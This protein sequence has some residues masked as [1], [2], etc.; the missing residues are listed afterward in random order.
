[1]QQV[2][3]QQV[4]AILATPE[5]QQQMQAMLEQNPMFQG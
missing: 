3:Q 5:G 4:S 2:M 1:M